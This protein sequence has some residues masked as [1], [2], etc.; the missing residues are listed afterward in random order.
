MWVQ[1]GFSS[2]PR[3]SGG[4]GWWERRLPTSQLVLLWTQ[5]LHSGHLGVGEA[6]VHE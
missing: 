3:R 4:G 1:M 5:L 6:S 2:G